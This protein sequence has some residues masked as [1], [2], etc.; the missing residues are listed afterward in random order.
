MWLSAAQDLGRAVDYVRLGLR[1]C[2]V[3]GDR[4]G[5]GG[6]CRAWMRCAR[7]PIRAFRRACRSAFSQSRMSQ[8]EQLSDVVPAYFDAGGDLT[9]AAGR[10]L[11]LRAVQARSGGDLLL[12][13]DRDLATR[14][15]AGDLLAGAA[16][17]LALGFGRAGY[18]LVGGGRAE[19]R[20]D[21][22]R[23]GGRGAGGCVRDRAGRE[24]APGRAHARGSHRQ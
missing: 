13:A 9:F 1:Q 11:S 5:L 4:H 15:G 3:P 20:G 10:D 14:I 19:C 8:T 16:P 18:G 7:C 12:S 21:G 6:C 22:L 23:A 17:V 24:R 2:R